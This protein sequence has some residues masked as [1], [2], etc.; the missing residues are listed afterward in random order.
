MSKDC[1]TCPFKIA[2]EFKRPALEEV[3]TYAKSLGWTTFD[4]ELFLAKLDSLGWVIPAGKLLIPV[5]DWRGVVMVWYKAATRRGEIK[6]QEKT[7][8]ERYDEAT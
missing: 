3:Q 1:K 8:K 5:A 6:F 4:G 2:A 7:F